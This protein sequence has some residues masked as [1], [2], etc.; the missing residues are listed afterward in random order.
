VSSMDIAF[1]LDSLC[2]SFGRIQAVNH[3]SLEVQAGEMVG[4]LGP[5][6]AGKSTTLYMASRLVR[7]SSGKIEIFGHDVWKDFKKAVRYVGTMVEMPSFYGYL[8]AHKNLEL[9]ARLRG[10]THD[11][12]IEDIL[13]IIGLFER[14]NDKVAT[15]SHGMKQRLGLGMSLIGKP[16]LLILD[17]PTNGMDPEG[18]REIMSFLRER[19][20]NDGLTVF[21]SSH[22]LYEIEE[23]CDKVVVINHGGLVASGKVKEILAP[24]DHVIQVTFSGIVPDCDKLAQEAA[25][26]HIEK[27][28]HNCLEIT[29][30]N[31]DSV[32]LG[33]YLWN[34]GYKVSALAPRRK[35][36]KE[37]F[38]SITGEKNDV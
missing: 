2:K 23:Y 10:N 17:E 31:Q 29:L 36:L 25:I 20:N 21:I 30:A 8:S 14:R 6:G 33:N 3:L 37:F 38:L 15:Y 1:R 26:V 34:K 19:I 7:P 18:T 27:L 22:L 5:N 24:H 13:K 12:Q 32:W 4:F 16:K 11:G 28:S 9:M 35:T